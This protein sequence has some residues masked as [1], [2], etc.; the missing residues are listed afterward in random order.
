MCQERGVRNLVA[1]DITEVQFSGLRSRFPE[2]LFRCQDA[3]RSVPAGP[4][5][6]VLLLDVI[7]HVV[8][9]DGLRGLLGNLENE[10]AAGGIMAISFPPPAAGRSNLYY[11]RFWPVEHVVK[12]LPRSELIRQVA[13][14]D[15][16]LLL[17][18]RCDR[19]PEGR[20]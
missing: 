15:G 18:R 8:T 14:R 11:L 2:Y 10:T 9:D 13:F 6:L 16:T 4:F 17:L 7:E 1:V 5:D 19:N 3:S 12:S 20:T